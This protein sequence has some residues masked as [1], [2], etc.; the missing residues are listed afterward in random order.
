MPRPCGGGASYRA[1]LL[2]P[3]ARALTAAAMLA[4]LSYGLLTLPLLLS[5]RAGT[6]SY[7]LAGT[8]T[9]LFGLAA[10]V[11]GPLRARLVERRPGTLTVLS[12]SYG[13]LLAGVA[14]GCAVDAP[15]W[16]TSALAV[17]AG[18]LPPPVGPLTRTMW[19]VLTT[20][21]A[22]RQAAL[23]LDTV[24]ESTV[25]ALGPLLGG[26]LIAVFNGP[27][28]LGACALVVVGGFSALSVALRRAGGLP[29]RTVASAAGR[30]R[31]SGPL[32]VPGFAVTLLVP[33]GLG[34]ALALEEIA[35][36]ALRHAGVAGSLMALLSAGGVLGGLAYGRRRWQVGPG[37]RLVALGAL[38]CA[39]FAVPVVVSPVAVVAAAFLLAGAC[40]D[41]ALIT[42]YL[43]VDV[44][45]PPGGRVEAGA[46]VN[47][48]YNLGGALG[49]GA[50][51]V[52]VDGWGPRSALIAATAL[53][54]GLVVVAAASGSLSRRGGGAETATV[55]PATTRSG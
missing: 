18:F 33:L 6:G 17:V 38:G 21:E 13:G 8:T 26:S 39:C 1:V 23:S 3:H 43:L 53:L 29:G 7:A 10:A 9:G 49:S 42:C 37:P 12:L 24:N 20:D 40:G 27:V 14:G 22:Q 31:S 28:A 48:A 19:G 45:V 32:T 11:F 25:F 30:G 15:W 36:V 55:E 4:R 47:T 16:V 34:A 35:M 46:W 2:L 41:T 44:L 5:L 50:A 54:G 52:L 51:G